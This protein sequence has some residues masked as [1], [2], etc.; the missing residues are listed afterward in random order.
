MS[1]SYDLLTPSKIVF[2]W[3]RRNE[4]GRLAK[5]LGRRAFLVSGSRTL[6]KQGVLE[7]L[8]NHLR[9]AEVDV[10][11]LASISHEP[12]V[13][14][15]DEAT[16]RL[17]SHD[18]GPGDLVIGIGGGAALDLAKALT[19]MA[20]NAESPTVKDYLE[21][22]GKGLSLNVPPLPM[23]AMPT[24]SGTGSE[25]TKNAVIS[26]YDPPF[27]KSLRS[28]QMVPKIVLADPELTVSAP[29]TVT[30]YS[31]MDAITQ[32]L[33]SYI[34]CRAKP[35]PKAL[36]LH[37]LQRALPAIKEVC[38]DGTCRWARENMAHAAL[39]SGIALANSGLGMA[40]GVAAALG[41][42][43]KVPHGLACAVMLPVALRVNREAAEEDLATLAPLLAKPGPNEPPADA[44]VRT[45]AELCDAVAIPKRLSEIG[46]SADQI[47]RIVTSSRG[48][49]MNGN[50]RELPD[51]ELTKILE[52]ML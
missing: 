45:I 52:E 22:V 50:P 35:I 12:E 8:T 20:T 34:S 51:D 30:A 46:V 6:E 37:G 44:L 13:T 21:G 43:A 7:E 40:H 11:P 24:T 47:P 48:N 26:S 3:G 33:E 49:S 5:S 32:L 23:L 38:R 15:V 19:A 17:R 36:A 25:A 9:E 14:D 4:V 41:V 1:L 2:G 28:E 42:H 16:A 31:G 10:I 18:P 39:L 27:K 29:P